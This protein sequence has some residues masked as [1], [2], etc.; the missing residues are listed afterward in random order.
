MS[1]CGAGNM[2]GE[3]TRGGSGAVC[4]VELRMEGLSVDGQAHQGVCVV[5]TR[6]VFE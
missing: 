1:F 2:D 3:R 6:G 4:A 5:R